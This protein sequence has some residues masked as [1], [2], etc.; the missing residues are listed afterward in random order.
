MTN[1]TKNKI[2][3]FLI[4]ASYEIIPFDG[5]ISTTLLACWDPAINCFLF[6]WEPIMTVMLVDVTFITGTSPTGKYGI[7]LLIFH[8]VK[9]Y[10]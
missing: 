6:Q 10:N 1:W 4:L 8:H 5:A 9:E 7:D 3:S 2:L